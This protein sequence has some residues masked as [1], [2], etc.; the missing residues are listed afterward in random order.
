MDRILFRLGPNPK[1]SKYFC[2]EFN[3]CSCT[4]L[5]SPDVLHSVALHSLSTHIAPPPSP[6]PPP[7]SAGIHAT[8]SGTGSWLFSC[9]Q[10]AK[11]VGKRILASPW[12][13]AL[14]NCERAQPHCKSENWYSKAL[15]QEWDKVGKVWQ[16]TPLLATGLPLDLA[17]M[18][19]ITG[20]WGLAAWQLDWWAS[21]PHPPPKKKK[22]KSHYRE[23]GLLRNEL[24]RS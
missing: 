14:P 16:Y 7:L 19:S 15:I 3:F 4:Q 12:V 8:G 23:R 18:D 10:A 6:P 13:C 1:S 17:W 24:W 21:S 5:S 9:G 20:V 2:L 22:Q 11:L